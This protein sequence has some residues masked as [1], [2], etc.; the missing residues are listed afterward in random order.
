[1]RDFPNSKL[2]IGLQEGLL[3][4]IDN[5][6]DIKTAQLMFNCITYEMKK[7]Q[8]K[9]STFCLDC[10]ALLLKLRQQIEMNYKEIKSEYS[11]IDNWLKSSTLYLK[12]NFNCNF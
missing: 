7:E 4:I 2:N 12:E 3:D 5:T 1:M 10:S 11:D 6:T 8:E 9:S